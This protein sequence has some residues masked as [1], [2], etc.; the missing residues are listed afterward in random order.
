MHN[1]SALTPFPVLDLHQLC[2]ERHRQVD[3]DPHACRTVLT[4]VLMQHPPTTQITTE[5]FNLEVIRE[6]ILN[7]SNNPNTTHRHVGCCSQLSRRQCDAMKR[8]HIVRADHRKRTTTYLWGWYPSRQNHCQSAEVTWNSLI[9]SNPHRW[10]VVWSQWIA[11]RWGNRIVG[12]LN[13]TILLGRQDSV[14]M[15]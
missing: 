8:C 12:K 5:R 7:N 15:L 14:P 9:L 3:N 13:N 2:T 6:W 1:T 10:K 4:I 11:T